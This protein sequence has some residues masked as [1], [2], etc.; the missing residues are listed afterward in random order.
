M[1]ILAATHNSTKARPERL[2]KQAGSSGALQMSALG[3]K[4]TC[5]VH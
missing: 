1:P 4:Q 5:A 3:Q 2:G